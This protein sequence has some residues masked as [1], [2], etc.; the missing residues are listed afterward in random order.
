MRFCSCVFILLIYFSS[1]A[2]AQQSG[3]TISEKCGTM[4][5]L[6]LTLQRNAALSIKFREQRSEFNRL[7]SQT[8]NRRRS[9]RME[10]ITYIPVVFHIVMSNPNVVTDAQIQAQLDTLNMDFAGT[11]GDS[12]K[13]PSYFKPYFGKSSIQFC[14]AQRT[15]DGDPTTGILRVNTS[16]SS[17]GINDAVKHT[18]SGGNDSWA[19]NNYFNVWICSLSNGILGYATFPADGSPSE[20]GVVIDY[21]S[22]P[23]GSYINYNNGKT[24]TH[25]TGHYFNLY[26]IWGDDNGAC[27]GTDYIADTPNQ[28]DAT[29]GCPTGIK[30]DSCTSTGNGIMYQNY[31]DYSYDPCLVMFT[32]EQVARMESALTTYRSSL[33]ASNGCK[34]V[35]LNNYDAQI[36]AIN[37]PGPRICASSFIPNISFRNKGIITLTSLQINAKVDN[38]NVVTTNWTG[39]LASFTLT[40]AALNAM[41]TTTGY[42]ILTIWTSNPNGN[43]DQDPT[44]DTLRINFQYYLPVKQVQESFESIIFPPTAWDIINPDNGITW[45]RITGVAKTGNASVMIDNHDYSQVGQKD[46]LRMPL[47]SIPAVTDSAF[48][49][50]QIAAA[51]YTDINTS[52]N[53]W[54]T[55]EVLASTDCGATYTSLYKKWGP[56]LVTDSVATIT[57]F[58]PS[59]NQWRKDSVNLANYIG[60]NNLLIAFR[61]TTG[62]ENNIYLDDVNLR[63]VVVNPNLKTQGV[64]VTPNPTNGIIVVQFYPQPVKLNAI[65]LFNS[66]GQK[67]QEFLIAKGKAGNYYSFNLSSYS[68]GTYYVRVV[69]ND[70]VVTK[71]IIKL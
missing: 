18:S 27:T 59:A 24:L 41:T 57:P 64:L 43:T 45:Q 63:T 47:I 34:P 36:R 53:I 29:S 26:H 52:G 3:R 28:A 7:L 71:K 12:V 40:S 61:N 11:N 23:G 51:T 9:L 55:L 66:V 2:S 30:L 35:V 60:S 25:E 48:L 70:S 22:I 46:D 58:S 54:D 42:H 6:Q 44:N 65:Q 62:Y 1:T 10:T 38:G 14:L 37:V 39:S 50:F 13:I 67:L 33:L 49:S 68:S 16:S 32:T 4:Q 31:M 69:F 19:T 17:F 8:Q 20:Q 15:P 21:R 5:H 56:N